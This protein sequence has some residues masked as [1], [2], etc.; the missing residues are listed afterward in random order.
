MKKTQ[1]KLRDKKQEGNFLQLLFWII[2][3]QFV[4]L[5]IGKMT[6]NNISVWYHGLIKSPLN[7][8]DFVFPIAWGFL[9]VILAIVGWYL[10]KNKSRNNGKLIFN[11][12]VIQI[13]MNWM[14]TPLFFQWHMIGLSFFWVV[15]MILITLVAFLLC[16]KH[17]KLVAVLLSP[18]L[19]WLIFASYLNY[20]VWLN[21]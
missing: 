2:A 5:L 4:G 21:N 8:P 12:Y 9:Y 15:A 1:S 6:Q 19:L 20:F 18:Y 14:W 17:F 10:Y 16:I 11:L 7:P 13:F 3:F